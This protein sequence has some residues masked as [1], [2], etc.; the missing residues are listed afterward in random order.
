MATRKSRYLA[1]GKFD[2]IIEKIIRERGAEGDS[3]YLTHEIMTTALKLID[4]KA[5]R[6]ELKILNAALKE[7]RYAFKI[8]SRYR[9][10]RKISVF[11]SARCTKSSPEYRMAKKF[12]REIARKDFMVITGAAS[13]IME[14]ANAGAGG[15]KSFGVN[16]RLPFEQEPNP[17]ISDDEKLITFKYFFTRKLIFVKESDA[18][19]LF[20]GGFGTQDEAFEVLTLIQTGK[21]EPLPIVMLE[22]PGRPYW[23]PWLRFLKQQVLGGGYISEDDFHLF[24]ITDS[25]EE[26]VT[27]ITHFYENYHSIRFVGGSLVMRMK[28][29]P[30][31][32]IRELNQKFGDLCT[33]RGQFEIVKPFPDEYDDNDVLGCARI[34]FP[35]NKQNFGRLRCMIDHIN[36]Y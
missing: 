28:R 5:G 8:F 1:G 18:I 9:D 10:S 14:A 7:L 13:G 21:S 16:I 24:K 2:K 11:G 30:E 20:P 36:R 31:K 25:I 33:K 23:R 32:M 35:F 12:S 6:G 19:A 34:G 15:T 22:Q 4:E 26:A 17:Y 27:E 29:V 3:V